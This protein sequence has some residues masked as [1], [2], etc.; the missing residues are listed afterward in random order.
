MKTDGSKMDGCFTG[1]ESYMEQKIRRD[2]NMGAN[3]KRLRWHVNC[4]RKSYVQNYRE[5]AATLAERHMRSM[6]PAN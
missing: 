2:R 5:G 6:N 3:L 1:E 4:H